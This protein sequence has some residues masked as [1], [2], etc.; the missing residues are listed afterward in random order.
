MKPSTIDVDSTRA[1]VTPALWLSLFVCMGVGPMFLYTLT[2]V[3]PLLIADLDLSAAQYGSISTVTFGAAAVSAVLLGGPSNRFRARTVMIAVSIGSMT[4]LAVMAVADSFT[5][6]LVA[7][8]LSGVAQA[9]SNPA[10]NRLV[11]G[12]PVRVRGALVGWKQSG[13]QAAQL[14]SGLAAPLVAAAAGW[15]W[16]AAIGLTVGVVGVVA[17][18]ATHPATGAG[19]ASTTATTASTGSMTVGALTAYTFCI[20]FGLQATN[21]HLP[22]FA[23]VRLGLD[24]HTAGLIAGVVGLI[25]LLSR[26]WWGRRTGD[27][28][29]HASTLVALALMAAVGVT[30]VLTSAAVGSWLVWI[31]AAVFGAAALASNSVTMVALISS[32][33][34]AS[35]GSA[36]A[37][38]ATGMYLGFGSG[39]LVFGLVL[40]LGAGFGTAWLIPIA[41][42]AAAALIGVA[43]TASRRPTNPE[44]QTHAHP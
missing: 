14:V 27:G 22:L 41:A 12:M 31:G 8:V 5:A 28:S 42:F 10:T 7:G 2:A 30:V 26:I 34:T 9:L 13:V 24:L 25:G 3:S 18:I 35:L 38:L 6:V 43:S 11:A 4:G 1:G 19:H 29:R 20:G 33:P 37:L 15:R 40:D 16:T 32:V 17:A 36:T 21:A 44:R 23:H 39:P